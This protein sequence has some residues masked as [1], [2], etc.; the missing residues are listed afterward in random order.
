MK[1]KKVLLPCGQIYLNVYILEMMR[2]LYRGRFYIAIDFKFSTRYE[3]LCACL[4]T[5]F[6]DFVSYLLMIFCHFIFRMGF[7]PT[8]SNN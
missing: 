2:N 1:L 5:H 6:S 7:F 4:M 8:A 3:L